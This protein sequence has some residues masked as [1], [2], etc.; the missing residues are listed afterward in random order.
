MRT[1]DIDAPSSNP[2]ARKEIKAGEITDLPERSPTEYYNMTP[3]G[4][5][6]SRGKEDH[7]DTTESEWDD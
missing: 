5:S 4:Y 1:V 2:W 6:G 7:G 3:Q